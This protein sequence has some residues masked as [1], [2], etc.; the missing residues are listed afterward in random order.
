MRMLLIARR[1]YCTKGKFITIKQ[2]RYQNA[3]SGIPTSSSGGRVKIG[4]VSVEIQR[5]QRPELVPKGYSKIFDLLC[6][7]KYIQ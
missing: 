5:P 3:W 4:D 1:G 7:T 6:V 2:K